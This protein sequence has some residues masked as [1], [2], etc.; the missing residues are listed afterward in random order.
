MPRYADD[1]WLEMLATLTERDAPVELSRRSSNDEGPPVVY[2]SRL[3]E[4]AQDGAIIVERPSQAVYD[5]AFGPGDDLELLLM[6]NGDRV[7]AT[8]TILN[9]HVRQLNGT[10]RVTCYKLSPGR[11]PQREQ[12]R[13]YYRVNVAAIQLDPVI[14]KILVPTQGQEEPGVM[15]VKGQLVNLSGGG[16]GVIVCAKRE[17]LG[18]LKRTRQLDCVASFDTGL[19]LAFPS[20]VAH[21]SARGEDLLYLGLQVQIDD[22]AYSRTIENQLLQLCALYQRAQLQ[23]RKA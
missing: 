18:Q 15:V 8:T 16:L 21:L 22:E 9:T 19:T 2:R 14:L 6:H 5:K 12:R 4:V 3:F 17:M 23:R 20:R 7:V 1:Q 13:A 10:L 11:R